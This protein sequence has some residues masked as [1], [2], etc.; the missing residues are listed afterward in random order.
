MWELCEEQHE[1]PSA[2]TVLP[3]HL[4][5][6]E[7]GDQKYCEDMPTKSTCPINHQ[8][9]PI[10]FPILTILYR[11][12]QAHIVILWQADFN[13]LQPWPLKLHFFLYLWHAYEGAGIILLRDVA[14]SKINIVPGLTEL[15]SLEVEIGGGG[16]RN[17]KTRSY[18]DHI[19]GSVTRQVLG[20]SMG[21]GAGQAWVQT[22]GSPINHFMPLALSVGL[23]FFICK[24]RAHVSACLMGFLWGWD[25][26]ISVE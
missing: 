22:L 7:V 25:A 14:V 15:T 11:L 23:S 2:Q 24:M 3:S 21:F 4:S 6:V 26:L 13:N 10:L 16:V 9:L 12:M 5:S 20:T 8:V 17:L 18:T 19:K 1:F